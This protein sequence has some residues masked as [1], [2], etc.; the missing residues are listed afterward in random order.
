MISFVAQSHGFGTDCLRFVPSFLTSTQNSLPGV[1][2][3][4]GWDSNVPT[5]FLRGVSALRLSLP[6]SLSWRDLILI[7]LSS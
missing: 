2:N 7:L 3:L 5:E 1:A 6:L 4:S